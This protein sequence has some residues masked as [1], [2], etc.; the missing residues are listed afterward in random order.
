MFFSKIFCN[1]I[2]PT[3]IAA[4]IF[5]SYLP[6]A[7]HEL[8]QPK[9][10]NK[11]MQQIFDQHVDK[12]EISASILKKSLNVY[13]DQFD[14]KRMYLTEKEVQPFLHPSDSQITNILSQYKNQQY[15]EYQDLN[16]VIQASILK[17]RSIREQLIRDNAR[18]L[19]QASSNLSV[20]DFE[21]WRDPDLKRTFAKDDAQLKERIRQEIIQFIAVER[22]R[23]G[24]AVL[25]SH[26]TQTFQI[27]EKKLRDH[28]NQYLYTLENGQPMSEVEKQNAFSMH[29]LKSLANS[30]DSH[31]TVLN[32]SEASDMRLRLEKKVEGIGVVMQ[33][34]PDGS[35]M[36]SQLV[37]GGAA[38]KSGQV[39]LGDRII[40]IDGKPT[41]GMAL[42][43]VME[44][45][46]GKDGVKKALVLQ[47]NMGGVKQNLS[48]QLKT[49]SIEVDDD[50]VQVT[51]EPYGNGIIGKIKLDTFYQSDS[52]ITSENDVRAAI[53]K[54]S[55]QGNLK[56]LILDFRENS[57]G[58]LSQAVKVAG[59]FI[60]NGVVV[61]S[62]YFNGEEHF[63]RD[64]DG[65]TSY[66]GPLIILTSK[67]TASAAEIVAQALQ[68]YGVAIIVGDVHTY[69]KGTIQSQ[70][71]TDNQGAAYFKVTVGK[72][73]TVSGK[74]PQI[75]GVKADVV[76][77]SQFV[78]DSI[79]EEYLEYALKPDVIAAS[80]D[81]TYTDVPA[82]LKSWYLH[83]YA[84]SLQHEKNL[85]R[86]MIPDLKK[87]SEYRIANNRNYQVFL[88]GSSANLPLSRRAQVE[89][90]QLSEAVN[91]AKDMVNLQSQQRRGESLKQVP[92]SQTAA[93]PAGGR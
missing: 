23:Y 17:S 80:Y 91:I 7:E 72:Y 85:W 22:K 12:K 18:E 53:K 38:M 6:A 2:T 9:D 83:Y 50:R 40:Q 3:V 62:K 19:F 48:V 67:V 56:A 79:G 27:W 31:T 15:P 35:F 70:T 51:S 14:P 75:Q 21:D 16:N 36:I 81:D 32:S 58:F 88:K 28:E 45:M 44:L 73:Y 49:G 5:C 90:L 84:P 63:Y 13:I 43:Q 8:L 30:L 54:L 77:P 47:R 20:S 68:D 59:L 10:V 57:G 26:Q 37:E 41:Q 1:Y 89:D 78:H 65:K 76:V 25:L 24:E 69:G 34:F 64:M 93:L 55:R 11:I 46:Q 52:G 60:T 66:D 39:K 71:V 33:Q 87:S 29:I 4:S 82:N 42:E 92:Q 86:N 74:T 61:V